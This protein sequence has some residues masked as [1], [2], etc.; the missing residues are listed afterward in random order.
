MAA[1]VLGLLLPFSIFYL[2]NLID[3]KI[4]SKSSLEK[5]VLN[6]PVLAELPRI[7]KNQD[8][9]LG[10]NDRSVLAESLRILR[11]NLDYL[12]KSKRNTKNNNIILVTSSVSGEG[13]TFVS[14]NLSMIFA[15]TKKKVLLIGADIRNPKIYTYFVDKNVDRM[16]YLKKNSNHGLSE[17]LFDKN[18]EL[19]DLINTMLV[20]NNTIDVIYS[21]KILPNPSELFE[22]RFHG[23]RQSR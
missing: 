10:D 3:T 1:L 23:T 5:S 15:S 22:C 19:K 20:H 8:K 11:T 12:L 21:G 18:V 17:Y 2:K 14:T 13:K 16:Q 6:Y 4:H 7:G 9:I